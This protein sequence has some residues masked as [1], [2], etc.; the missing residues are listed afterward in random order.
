MRASHG[1]G[2]LSGSTHKTTFH[3]QRCQRVGQRCTKPTSNQ[4][5]GKTHNTFK[6]EYTRN[7]IGSAAF[8]AIAAAPTATTINRRGQSDLPS[9]GELPGQCLRRRR[10]QCQHTPVA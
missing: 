3:Y 10:Q 5:S 1:L 2:I 6:N 9:P 8:G 4:E 7:T